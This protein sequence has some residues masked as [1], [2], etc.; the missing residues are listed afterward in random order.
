MGTTE[1]VNAG[2]P[3]KLLVSVED[4]DEVFAITYFWPK[5]GKRHEVWVEPKASRIPLREVI[6]GWPGDGAHVSAR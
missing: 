3:V 5:T 4:P 2:F 1:V 6:L